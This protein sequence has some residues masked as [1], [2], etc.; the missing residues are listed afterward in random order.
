MRYAILFAVFV[1]LAACQSAPE[2]K[3]D[4]AA[5]VEKVC[6]PVKAIMLG[7]SSSP[8]IKPDVQEKLEAVRPYV[9]VAC[10]AQVAASANDLFAL[11]DNALP[12]VMQAIAASPLDEEKKQTALLAITVAQIAIAA[13]R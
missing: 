10:S 5:T 6:P 7:L 2:K 1:G 3:V 4:V 13:A 12:V 11:S 8:A 9:D